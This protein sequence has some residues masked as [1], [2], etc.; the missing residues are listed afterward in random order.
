MFSELLGTINS[1][2]LKRYLFVS[3][4][5]LTHLFEESYNWQIWKEKGDFYFKF[6]NLTYT[7]EILDKNQFN[8]YFGFHVI[9]DMSNHK[10]NTKGWRIPRYLLF[11]T[12]LILLIRSASYSNDIYL[13][14]KKLLKPKCPKLS[15]LW[16]QFWRGQ[17]EI[18]LLLSEIL[19]E[20][21]G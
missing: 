20:M 21:V 16:D 7:G 13:Q 8:N 12:N 3:P 10:S 14:N 11:Y 5:L 9:D 2:V 17:K 18:S 4:N 19:P 6:V 15:I 1:I